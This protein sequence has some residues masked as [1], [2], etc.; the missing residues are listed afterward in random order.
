MI[1]IKEYEVL[2]RRHLEVYETLW[3]KKLKAMNKLEPCGGL[4]KK[5][6][7]TRYKNQWYEENKEIIRQKQKQ[8]YEENKEAITEQS[9]QYYKDNKEELLNK[10]KQYYE[11]NKENILRRVKQYQE[12]NQEK[13]KENKTKYYE[14]NKEKIKQTVNEYGKEK[15]TCECGVTMRKDSLSRHKNSKKHLLASDF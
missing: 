2:D 11:E 9:K 15:N 1:L 4:L 7:E 10:Q 12:R 5:Q 8:Y 3:I 6:R 13:I 14:K